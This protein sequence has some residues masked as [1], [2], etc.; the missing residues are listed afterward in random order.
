MFGVLM[1]T[2][3]A[4]RRDER[5]RV[6]GPPAASCAEQEQRHVLLLDAALLAERALRTWRRGLSLCS[7]ASPGSN[8]MERILGL[9]G[10]KQHVQVKESCPR[11][12]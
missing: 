6:I 12:P 8:E 4:R 9:A 5:L 3:Y 1:T 10:I 7:S 11:L 2:S